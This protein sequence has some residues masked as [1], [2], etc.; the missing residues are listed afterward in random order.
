MSM[1]GNDLNNTIKEVR[2]FSS[3]MGRAALHA[4]LPDE[5]EYYFCSLELLDSSGLTKGYLTFSVMPNNIMDTVTQV[6][7]V[8]KTNSGVISLFNDSFSPHDISIQ[9]SFGRKMRLVTGIQPSGNVSTIPFFG[10]N[11]GFK[12]GG[13]NAYVKTGYGLTK[14]LEHM[15]EAA[16][17]LD[18]KNKPH[19]LILTNYANNTSYVVEPL[20]RSTSQGIEN[21][22]IWFYSIEFKAVAPGNIVKSNFSKR[23]KNQYITNVSS[24][25]ISKGLTNLI[26]S[27]RKKFPI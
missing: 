12:I 2:S 22:M 1:F 18:D 10:M 4:L 8:T 5:I 21:N 27:T 19:I 13:Q 6:A 3:S 7:S 25:A 16:W 23:D 9:G 26:N 11:T 20:Q 14:L 17:Q 15:L 24:A